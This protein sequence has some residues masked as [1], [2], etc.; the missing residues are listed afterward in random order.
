MN[1]AL[2]AH[3]VL[4]AR[5]QF[6]PTANVRS[7]ARTLQ[8]LLTRQIEF[9]DA[10]GDAVY[11]QAPSADESSIGCHVRH[12]LDHVRALLEGAAV[13][14][15]DYD[16][17]E[18]GTNVEQVRSA[19][20]ARTQRHHDELTRLCVDGCDQPVR[21]RAMLAASGP[22]VTLPSQLAR[23]L[24]FVLSHTLHHHALMAIVARALAAPVPPRFGC[25]PATIAFL[26][27]ASCVR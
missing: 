15:I 4:D 23:E 24:V 8:A 20:I 6:G 12:C 1:A 17:R 13:G 14:V 26:E 27:S 10:L 22:T 11:A 16:A 25:A 19:G 2:M 9:L 5:A 3:D 7:A 18:R 21:V